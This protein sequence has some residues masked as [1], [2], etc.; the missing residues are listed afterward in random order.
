M[1]QLVHNVVAPPKAERVLL[2]D[3]MVENGYDPLR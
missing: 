2:H 3:L 1:A